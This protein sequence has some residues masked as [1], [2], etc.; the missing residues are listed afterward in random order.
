MKT[1]L[2]YF[3]VLATV[4]MTG[5]LFTSCDTDKEETFESGSIYGSW[6]Q[7]YD[8]G[9]EMKLTFKKNSTGTVTYYSSNGDMQIEN[10]TFDYHKD[11][12]FLRI[13]ETTCILCGDYDVAVSAKRLDLTGYNYTFGENMWFAFER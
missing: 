7:T 8:D 11:N 5:A 13:L 2:R 6:K 1:L 10:F 3:L 12:R 9:S 4:V